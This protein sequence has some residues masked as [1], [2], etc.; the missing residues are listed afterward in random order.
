M[1]LAVGLSPAWQR[2]LVFDR[3]EMGEVNR[4]REA[5]ECAS[6]KVL[7]VGLALSSLGAQATTLSIIGGPTGDRIRAE[8]AQRGVPARWI[9]DP[10]TT[11]TCTTLIEPASYGITELVENASLIDARSWE[12]FRAAFIEEAA[13]ADWVVLSGSLPPIAGRPPTALVYRELMEQCRGRVILDARGTELLGGL[14]QKPFLVKPNREELAAT[15]GRPIS[16]EKSLI[17]AMRELNARGAEWVLVTDGPRAVWLAS[18]ME[19]WRFTPEHINFLNPIGC[20]DCLAAGLVAALAE[21]H[22][23]PEAV[24]W[25]MAAAADNALQLLPARLDRARM[26]AGASRVP[27]ERLA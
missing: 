26:L 8:F 1:I 10:S 15:V 19:R 2:I 22:S 9:D 7:N 5:H 23:C 25:G 13:T 16:D 24:S 3:V 27:G 17:A 21:G 4:A 18:V 12:A 14:E 6:G 20:G 11:R